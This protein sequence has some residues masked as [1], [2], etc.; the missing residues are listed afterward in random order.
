LARYPWAF[1]CGGGPVFFPF[2]ITREQPIEKSPSWEL[3][4]LKEMIKIRVIR[5]IDHFA[6]G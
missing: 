5:R 4:R 1:A 2:A 6:I 3:I